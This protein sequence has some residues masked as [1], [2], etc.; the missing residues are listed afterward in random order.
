MH[1]I[2]LGVSCIFE[3][4]LALSSNWAQG[5][6]RFWPTVV[7][8]IVGASGIYTLSL[9]LRVI[10]VSV[11]YTIWTGIGSVGTVIF[12]MIL[13]NERINAIKLAGFA[14]IIVGV[15]GLRMLTDF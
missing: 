6:T 9:A 1:W 10:D 11:G 5:F 12:G 7:T 14:S 3:I 15:I 13:F 4:M 8:V 2:Y